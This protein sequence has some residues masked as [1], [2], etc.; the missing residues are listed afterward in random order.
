MVFA[1]TAGGGSAC[2]NGH[3]SMSLMQHASG[4]I[5][6]FS[7]IPTPAGPSP[8][9]FVFPLAIDASVIIHSHMQ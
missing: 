4:T 8:Q 3:P 2:D 7:D 6:A 9:A 1:T 5:I